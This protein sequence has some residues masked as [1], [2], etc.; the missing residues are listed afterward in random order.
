MSE[1]PR[2]DTSDRHPGILIARGDWT[3]AHAGAMLAL[4]E[5][6]PGSA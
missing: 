4:I 3:L 2:I 1:A 6:A 5:S